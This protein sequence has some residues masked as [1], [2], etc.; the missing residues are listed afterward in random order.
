MYILL[1]NLPIKVHV[2]FVSSWLILYLTFLKEYQHLVYDYAQLSH[3]DMD[4]KP[5]QLLFSPYIFFSNL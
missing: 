1:V 5:I 2:D 3:L 4:S